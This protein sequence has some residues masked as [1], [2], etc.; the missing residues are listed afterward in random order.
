MANRLVCVFGGT[1]FLGRRVVRQLVES[2]CRVRV[3]ARTPDKT[4]FAGVDDALL[5]FC[6]VDLRDDG[7][8]E[9]VLA[10]AQGAVNA[11]SLYVERPGFSF[12]DIHAR[13]AD[14]LARL[15]RSAGLDALAYVSGIGADA[16]SDSALVRAKAVGER[17]VAA[18]FPGAYIVRPSVMFGREDAFLSNL[19]M[20]TR[21]PVV[22]LFG[23]GHVRMQP[24]W[25]EDVAQAIAR[26]VGQPRVG[27]G[28]EQVLEFGG[29]QTL[30]YRE[31]VAAVCDALGRRRLLLPVPLGVWKVLA[32]AMGVLTTPPLT[33]DQIYLLA[34]D[35]TVAPSRDGFA[36]LGMQPAGMLDLLER[37]LTDG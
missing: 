37:C 34:R 23:A 4:H 1:G 36:Q 11:V 9:Q 3:V 18:S 26:L 7:A 31:A 5:E 15:S 24:A 19:K 33:I 21:L 17:L 8:V 10:G 27:E 2:G 16:D 13:G 22:P 28:G 12:E 25:V 32:R 14:R 30:S 29:A 35:N 6:A 20:A